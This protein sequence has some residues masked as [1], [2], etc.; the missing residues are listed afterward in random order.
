MFWLQT[1]FELAKLLLLRKTQKQLNL[2]LK[3]IDRSLLVARAKKEMLFVSQWTMNSS[4]AAAFDIRAKSRAQTGCDVSFFEQME[5]SK[6]TEFLCLSLMN[7]V[8]FNAFLVINDSSKC[9]R[10]TFQNRNHSKLKYWRAIKIKCPTIN[11]RLEYE[12]LALILCASNAHARRQ[13]KEAANQHF[14]ICIDVCST[15]FESI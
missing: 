8:S 6:A 14:K 11:F 2:L 9:K 10:Q 13:L 5:H 3:S 4:E 15:R 1:D 12:N 7:Y